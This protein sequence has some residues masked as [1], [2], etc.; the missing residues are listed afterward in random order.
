M[1]RMGWTDPQTG[2]TEAEIIGGLM[3][4][5]VWYEGMPDNVEVVSDGN[6]II[7]SKLNSESLS[8]LLHQGW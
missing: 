6:F 1:C 3:E 4:V 8:I 2:D 7:V 5:I